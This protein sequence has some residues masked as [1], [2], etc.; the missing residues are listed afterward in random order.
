[1]T[2]I[3]RSFYLKLLLIS[4]WF[5]Y[6]LSINLNPAEFSNLNLI[7]KIRILLPIFLTIV[8]IKIKLVGNYLKIK[9]NP[10]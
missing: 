7:N 10:N 1:M 9:K 6:F 5:S 2:K 4:V 8:L 3:K